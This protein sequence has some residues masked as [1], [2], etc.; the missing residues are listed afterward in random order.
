MNPHGCPPTYAFNGW[1]FC[2]ADGALHDPNGISVRLAPA[3][4]ALLAL[5]CQF[6]QQVLTLERLRELGSADGRFGTTTALKLS[7]FRLRQ[8][9]TDYEG[10]AQ[11]V[12][13]VRSPR[14]YFFSP[15]VTASY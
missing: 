6:P 5:F 13:F 8:A 4:V 3:Q 11:M 10:D 14:G 9:M 2:P 15:P 12:V 1:R 7:V